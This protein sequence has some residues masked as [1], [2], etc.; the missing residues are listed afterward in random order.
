MSEKVKQDFAKLHVSWIRK[1][2]YFQKQK[3]EVG[4]EGI[5]GGKKQYENK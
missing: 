1:E 2:E 3:R 4:E 5:L